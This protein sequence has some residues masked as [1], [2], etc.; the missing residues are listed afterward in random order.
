MLCRR[1]SFLALYGATAALC[2][3][4]QAVLV[5]LPAVPEILFADS[6]LFVLPSVVLAKACG[7]SDARASSI[8]LVVP[9]AMWIGNPDPHVRSLLLT[10]GVGAAQGMSALLGMRNEIRERRSSPARWAAICIAIVGVVDLG[11]VDVWSDIAWT[12]VT[13][14]AFVCIAYLVD[15]QR[16]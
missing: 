10:L 5:R 9:C 7:A 1:W 12:G 2:A 3:I 14:H 6:I 8:F 16:K 11:F 13:A 15:E 4:G